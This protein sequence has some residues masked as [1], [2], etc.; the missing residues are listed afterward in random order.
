[1]LRKV[2]NPGKVKKLNEILPNMEKWE[3][4]ILKLKQECQVDISSDLRMAILL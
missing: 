4:N 3:L 2:V 1:M